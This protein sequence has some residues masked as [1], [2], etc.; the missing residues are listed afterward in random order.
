ML[1]KWSLDEKS[2][3]VQKQKQDFEDHVSGQNIL[4]E[5]LKKR[6]AATI[7]S[8]QQ[9]ALC[10]QHLVN[11]EGL[12]QL[13]VLIRSRC[14]TANPAA[15]TKNKDLEKKRHF[16][17]PGARHSHEHCTRQSWLNHKRERSL[18]TAMS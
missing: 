11:F 4:H 1:N 6:Q 18:A 2:N 3:S 16:G 8:P 9:H 5:T 17:P 7:K 14:A 12:P 10:A 15:L 13:T